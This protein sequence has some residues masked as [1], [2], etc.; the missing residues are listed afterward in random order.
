[1]RCNKGKGLSVRC[2]QNSRQKILT[3]QNG[4]NIIWNSL[5]VKS[6]AAVVEKT[7]I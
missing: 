5:Q 2:V 7:T 1:M 6:N 4:E 3:W